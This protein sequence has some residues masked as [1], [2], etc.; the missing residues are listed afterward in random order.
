[1]HKV[2]LGQLIAETI[3]KNYK[4]TS[5][6]LIASDNAFSFLTSVKRTP[7]YR[8]YFLNNALAMV[9]QLGIPIYFLK[10]YCEDPKVGRTSIYHKQIE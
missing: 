8:K 1:M 9:K 5:G 2:K 7:T 3:K 4:D 6:K 10:L